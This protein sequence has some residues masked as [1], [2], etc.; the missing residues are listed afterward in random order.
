MFTEVS[1]ILGR[2]GICIL[3]CLGWFKLLLIQLLHS[4][5]A[6]R[7]LHGISS[8]S[9][10]NHRKVSVE[11]SRLL[12]HYHWQMKKKSMNCMR[13]RW[14]SDATS[15]LSIYRVVVYVCVCSCMWWTMVNV[16]SP[17]QKAT[18]KTICWRSIW[19]TIRVTCVIV[20][21]YT[22]PSNFY[23]C[24]YCYFRFVLCA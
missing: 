8:R 2:Y 20:H 21:I 16:F 5:S 24:C 3:P 13:L 1:H 4:Y 17:N 18:K 22:Q 19:H 6:W 15:L 14:N 23:H 11:N 7:V 10:W 12:W 9:S